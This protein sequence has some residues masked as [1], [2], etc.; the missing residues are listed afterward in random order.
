V[1]HD[2]RIAGHEWQEQLWLELVRDDV[3]RILGRCAGHLPV[4]P[5][6]LDPVGLDQRLRL[7]AGH[8]HRP[9]RRAGH[10][11]NHDPTNHTA[12]AQN[13][14]FD[15]GTL[16]QGQSR[17]LVFNKPGTYSYYCPFHAFMRAKLIVVK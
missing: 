5:G 1:D 15:T 9:G 3:L 8:D 14:S 7:R 16:A 6:A 11:H 2:A 4:L 13:Q 17:T 12:T 10:V